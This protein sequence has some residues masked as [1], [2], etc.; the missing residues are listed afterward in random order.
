[1]NLITTLC[2]ILTT[3]FLAWETDRSKPRAYPLGN[4]GDILAG[5]AA[6]ESLYI[7]HGALGEDTHESL[8][9]TK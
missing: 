1:M 4:T 3:G 5:G 8:G 9:T 6:L 7:K 2:L